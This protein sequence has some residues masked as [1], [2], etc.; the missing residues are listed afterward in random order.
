MESISD[1]NDFTHW[2]IN[3]PTEVT[4]AET[5]LVTFIVGDSSTCDR[6]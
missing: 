1:T 5:E 2:T 3:F 4:A 6:I